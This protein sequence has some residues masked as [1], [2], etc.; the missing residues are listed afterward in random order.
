MITAKTIRGIVGFIIVMAIML[1]GN[2][3]TKFVEAH[4]SIGVILLLG[5]LAFVL[6]GMFWKKNNA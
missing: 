3:I 1:C 4:S 6:W 2:A 5:A